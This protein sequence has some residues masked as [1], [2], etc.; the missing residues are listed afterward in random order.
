MDR[1]HKKISLIVIAILL[2][3]ILMPICSATVKQS[4]QDPEPDPCM[5]VIKSIEIDGEQ[6]KEVE[7]QVGSI[8]KF[9][10]DV[11]Y[12]DIDGPGN[13]E[14]PNGYVL[15]EI[16]ITDILPEGLEYISATEEPDETGDEIYWD[17]TGEKLYDEVG[18]NRYTLK[19]DV[20]VKTNGT[21]ENKVEVNAIEHCYGRPVYNE[22]YA[23]VKTKEGGEEEDDTPPKVKIERPKENT[24]YI[25][26]EE[27]KELIFLKTIISG[28]IT[29]EVNA[30][31]DESGIKKVE[32]YLSG[33]KLGEDKNA[34]YKFTI[35]EETSITSIKTLKV[36]AIDNSGNENSD[37]IKFWK[38]SDSNLISKLL[39]VGG[40]LIVTSFILSLIKNRQADDPDKTEE[41]DDESDKDPNKDINSEPVAKIRGP[42]EGK[43]H[44]EI[45]FDASGSHDPD[46]DQLEYQWHFGD[47][48]SG[49]TGEKVTHI[50]TEEGEY[51]VKLTVYDNKG[52]S[53]TD[54]IVINIESD[55]QKA[56]IL[57]EEIDL[58]WLIVSALGIALLA[59]LIVFYLRRELYV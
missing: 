29:V 10:I 3:S 31:D 17:I 58:F 2:T 24:L 35:D 59:A 28:P 4:Y 12:H 50:Y 22:S 44:Q 8:I 33:I 7:V 38:I 48:S 27:I 49:K 9:R 1:F 43:V 41:K 30:T 51:T 34:P 15:E 23:T 54:T 57:G 26:D 45:T 55:K 36:V 46:D 39:K 37:E 5:E 19:F 42:Y 16:K 13:G 21:F 32:F 25:D 11:I 6:Y 20:E 56:V 40:V 18:K 47:G 53:S 14:D 52:G